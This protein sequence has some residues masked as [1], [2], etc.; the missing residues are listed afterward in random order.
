MNEA[1]AAGVYTGIADSCDAFFVGGWGMGRQKHYPPQDPHHHHDPVS[2]GSTC[3]G[4]F[5][6]KESPQVK[7]QVKT[8]VKKGH[9][10]AK[11]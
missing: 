1:G 2:K 4:G 11:N 10:K 3:T 7:I 6:K 8:Q 5:F 9:I